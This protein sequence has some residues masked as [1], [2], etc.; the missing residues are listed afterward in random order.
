MEDHGHFHLAVEEWVTP[1]V[2]RLHEE[3]RVQLGLR[4]FQPW[5]LPVDPAGLLSFGEPNRSA[6]E[7]VDDGLVQR[8]LHRL[9]VSAM[10]DAFEQWAYSHPEQGADPVEC[11][12]QWRSLW[13]R[14][15]PGVD[16]SGLD[17][18]L[19]IEWQRHA[20]L[21]LSPLFSI[22]VARVQIGAIQRWARE[23]RQD[24]DA[25]VR[26]E[27]ALT[28]GDL[29]DLPAA[30]TLDEHAIREG[31]EDANGVGVTCGTGPAERSTLL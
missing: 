25:L 28:R 10:G 27:R 26:F 12:R 8:I 24:G 30:E 11:S 16:W 5:D 17:E 4:R 2:V 18:A 23:R 7:A 6:A 1:V 3:R 9:T 29:S 22:E 19:E 15:L 20:H 14:F 21:F 31:V 13:L